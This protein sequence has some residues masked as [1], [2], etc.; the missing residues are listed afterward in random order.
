M[1]THSMFVKLNYL[2]KLVSLWINTVRGWQV[3]NLFERNTCGTPA[4]VRFRRPHSSFDYRL[5]QT[6]GFGVDPPFPSGLRLWFWRPLGFVARG[7]LPHEHLRIDRDASST[8][9]IMKM[10]PSRPSRR[11]DLAD[12]LTLLDCGPGGDHD[13]RQM[14]VSRSK[15]V[16]MSDFYHVAIARH[17][18]R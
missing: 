12:Q 7:R 6:I 17:P 14:P 10:R 9:F 5:G 15:A 2:L 16:R 1:G 13:F 11:A 18:T 8:D 3:L 4:P